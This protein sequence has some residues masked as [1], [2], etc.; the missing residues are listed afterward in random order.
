MRQSRAGSPLGVGKGLQDASLGLVYG[1]KPG[2]QFLPPSPFTVATST[3][4]FQAKVNQ[5]CVISDGV[6]GQ[7]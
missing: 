3:E 6:L 5:L 7:H 1:D 2:L 4:G